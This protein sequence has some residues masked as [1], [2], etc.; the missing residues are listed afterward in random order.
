MQ[1]RIEALFASGILLAT[2]FSGATFAFAQ[3]TRTTKASGSLTAT[4]GSCSP[5]AH[6]L[7]TFGDHVYPETGNGGYRSLHTAVHLDYDGTSNLFLPGTAVDLTDQATQ[8]LSSFSLDFERTSPDSSAGPDLT[9]SAV[10]VNGQPASYSFVQP[11]YPGDPAGPNDPNPAAHEASQSNPVGGPQDNSLPPS[12]SP[13]LESTSPADANS[14][15]GTQCPANKLVITPTKPIKNGSKFTVSVR[16]TGRPGIHHDGDGSVE[17][18][19]RASDGGFVTTEP[20]GSEDWMPLNNFPTAKPSYHFYDTTNAG[21]TAIANG[22][23]V[24][25]TSH[26]PN[27]Q[28]QGSSTTWHWHEASPVASYLV[29]DSI[30]NYKLTSRTG[31]NGV[32]YYV[33]QDDSIAPDQQTKNQAVINQQQDITKFESQFN[34][35]YPFTSAG[36][37]VGTPPVGFDEE[38]ETM[39][40][41]SLGMVQPVVLYHETMHQWWGD[42]V[43]E[44]NYNLVFY[45]EGFG[46]LAQDLLTAR[47]AQVTHGGPN[48]ATGKAA[49]EDSLVNQFN[50]SYSDASLWSQAPSKPTPF[51]LF[52]QATTYNRPAAAYIALRQ[53]LGPSNFA[54]ALQQM[55]HQY[56]GGSIN[57]QEF[58]AAFHQ[59][60][61]V[62]SQSCNQRLNTFFTEWFDTAYPSGGSNRPQITGPGL[63]GSGFYNQSGGCNPT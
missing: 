34:G 27:G 58:E 22:K 55:Q 6:T 18:W 60:M 53:I 35:P 63:A 20:V 26:V 36:V 3:T 45:K 48:K 41:I 16:Y 7:S 14:L 33:A 42:N 62:K 61:P 25:S 29:E 12:C 28:F 8:C 9:V 44:S 11:T 54:R 4:T 2:L 21:K 1:R 5:G 15:D 47:T 37:I 19:F 51:T 52:S 10:T 43:T 13:E 17:G 30:G 38:M 50:V 49:F 56:G 40:T 32:R 39:I 59:W 23:L 46:Q 57:E 31:A 24:S